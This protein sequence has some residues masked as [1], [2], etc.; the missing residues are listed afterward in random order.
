MYQRRSRIS[1][2]LVGGVMSKERPKRISDVRHWEL[3]CG[4]SAK[5][6]GYA[7]EYSS[8]QLGG[9]GEMAKVQQGRRGVEG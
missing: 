6:I 3:D 5:E 8:W 7:L 2:M 1:S 4:K 9:G